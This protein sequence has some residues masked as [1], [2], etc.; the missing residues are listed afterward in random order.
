[1]SSTILAERLQNIQGWKATP[2]LL[3]AEKSW[4]K[5]LPGEGCAGC[6]SRRQRPWLPS[7]SLSGA[8]FGSQC[9][10][11]TPRRRSSIAQ[12]PQLLEV[13][14]QLSIPRTLCFSLGAWPNRPFTR[15][16]LLAYVTCQGTADLQNVRTL[17]HIRIQKS[18][19]WLKLHFMS[20]ETFKVDMRCP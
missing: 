17:E 6:A 8:V 19:M 4:W 14:F 3:G 15:I 16:L 11:S 20:Q 18:L 5:P 10:Q 13:G 7:E 9:T 2:E 1:M 12:H